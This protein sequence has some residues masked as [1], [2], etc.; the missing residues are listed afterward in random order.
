MEHPGWLEIFVDAAHAGSGSPIVQFARHGGQTR[1]YG[2]GEG[3]EKRVKVAV[4]RTG[5]RIVYEWR[6]EVDTELD[7]DRAIGFDVSVSDKDEDGSFSWAAWG[8]GTQKL[9]MPDRVGEFFLVSPG[10]RFGEVSGL[11]AW[12]DPSQASV[13]SRVRIQSTRIAP[14]WLER[15]L[16]SSGA[17]RATTL[18][19][20]PYSIRAV[21]SPDLRVE[22]KTGVE[23]LVEADRVAKAD[24]LRVTP[25]PWPGLVGAEGVLL[26]PGPVNPDELDRF[27]R[28]YLDYFRIPGISVAV[29]KDSRVVYH[30]GLG[31]KNAMTRE[32]SAMTRCSRPPP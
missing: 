9:D 2:P 18:P 14:L 16:N 15:P 5:A 7:P 4:A 13:P 20:G 23:V 27:V 3:L 26:R 8:S 12:K 17:Y 25:I 1:A 29:I 10:T 24:L 22:A 30:R 32:P 6:I 21:D 19:P 31:V 28:A 11:V